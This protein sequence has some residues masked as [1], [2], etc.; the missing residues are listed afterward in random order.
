ME[1]YY[2]LQMIHRER[3]ENEGKPIRFETL[4]KAKKE[5]EKRQNKEYGYNIT[6][7]NEVCEAFEV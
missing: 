6:K 2:L 1:K 5:A 7:V 3:F 4:E